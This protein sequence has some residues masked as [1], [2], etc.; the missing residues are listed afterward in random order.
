MMELYLSTVL[1]IIVWRAD[2]DD[3]H[4][5]PRLLVAT[6]IWILL[7]PTQEDWF[8]FGTYFQSPSLRRIHE[9]QDGS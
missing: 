8:E 5:I 9:K 7:H 4:A 1:T 2:G 3:A 6:T